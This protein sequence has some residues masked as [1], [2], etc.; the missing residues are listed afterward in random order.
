MTADA[1]LAQAE[2]ADA[3]LAAGEAGP[4]TGIPLAHKDI[5]CT[6]GVRTSCGSRMLDNFVSPY[7]AFAVE[8][9]D[10]AGMITLARPTWTSSPWVRPTRPAGTARC[11]TPGT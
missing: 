4:L 11:R 7:D 1:A 3:V 9:L 5:F 2:A 10:E 6:R 8:R